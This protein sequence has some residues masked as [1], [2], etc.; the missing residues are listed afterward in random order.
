MVRYAKPT[1]DKKANKLIA[2]YLGI[3][4]H[5]K[6]HETCLEIPDVRNTS[7]N[8]AAS[9]PRE[10]NTLNSSR[11]GTDAILPFLHHH[12][13]DAA[14]EIVVSIATVSMLFP[15][16]HLGAKWAFLERIRRWDLFFQTR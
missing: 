4:S 8:G 9:S 2:P 13:Y 12:L 11:S 3:R 16:Y 6:K 15:F 14:P 5:T 10:P 7:R 1:Y